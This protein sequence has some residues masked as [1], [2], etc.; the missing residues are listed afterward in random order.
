MYLLADGGATKTDWLLFDKKGIR[1]RSKTSGINLIVQSEVEVRTGPFKELPALIGNTKIEQVYY[2]GAGLRTGDKVEAMQELLKE[3]FPN[4]QLFVYHDLLGAARAAC[5]HKQGIT[6]ILGTGSN[7]C[8]YDGGNVVSEAGGH[9]YV[10][11]DEGSGTDLGKT[12]IKMALDHE[13]HKEIIQQ[14]EAHAGKSLFEIRNEAY[15]HP[16]PN[17]YFASFSHLIAANIHNPV[18]YGLVLGRFVNFLGKTVLRYYG[19]AD[20]NLHFVGSVAG[21]YEKVLREACG[22]FDLKIGKVIPAPAEAL[23]AY[24]LEEMKP[25]T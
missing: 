6:C 20:K 21:I 23:V 1:S 24:H 22:Y 17:Y 9:G 4:A 12:L 15:S 14:I 13:L 11:G 3:V 19:Y 7:S 18:Y 16:K 8:W 2:Y 5:G 10:L 25:K